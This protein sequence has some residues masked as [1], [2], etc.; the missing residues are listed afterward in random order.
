MLDL[1]IGSSGV[2]LGRGYYRTSVCRVC[3]CVFCKP[4]IMLRSLL[5]LVFWVFFIK[6]WN[7]DKFC[8]MLFLHLLRRSSIVIFV[9]LMWYNTLFFPLC[10]TKLLFL[11][12]IPLSYDV[13]LMCYW[14]QFLFYWECL[15]PLGI[16]VCNSHSLFFSSFGIMVVLNW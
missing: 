7:S 12:W 8:Q 13:L 4:F 11:G 3:V 16:L 1:F 2:F 14:L 9:I 5:L 6:S 10:W 15:Y